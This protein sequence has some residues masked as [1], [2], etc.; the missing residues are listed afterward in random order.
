MASEVEVRTLVEDAELAAET[1]RLNGFSLAG[2]LKQ[3]DIMHDKPDGQ[4][5]LSG[6]K[7]RIR[8]EDDRAELT[9]KG[10]FEG[11]QSASRRSEINITIP[12]GSVDDVSLVLTALGYPILFQVQKTRVVL[13]NGGVV[14]TIDSWPIIGP[15]LELEGEEEEIKS[16][17]NL[18]FPKHI[19]RN[20]RLK[21]LFEEVCSRRGKSLNELQDEYEKSSRFEL[22][23]IGF[24]TR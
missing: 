15:M 12:A 24:L 3:R 19:F 16:I 17:A 18:L 1:L 5:F 13:R 4:L 9:Y 8:V 20:Y 6:Q 23:N 11:D 10:E 2:S 21:E 14:A 22:G 7:I